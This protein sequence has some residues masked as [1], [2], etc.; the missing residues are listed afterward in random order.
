MPS[1]SKKDQE[2]PTTAVLN[3]RYFSHDHDALLHMPNSGCSEI[4]IWTAVMI[5]KLFS[6]CFF[7][8]ASSDLECGSLC[9]VGSDELAVFSFVSLRPANGR[10][11]ESAGA[12]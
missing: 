11:I 1:F 10:I 6:S 8:R 5:V 9:S 3:M 4:L 2:V 12:Q 7:E